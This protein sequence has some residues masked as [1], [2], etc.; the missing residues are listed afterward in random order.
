M[1]T[2]GVELNLSGESPHYLLEHADRRR[3]LIL[4]HRALIDSTLDLLG[5]DKI[6]LQPTNTDT[7][8]LGYGFDLS[9]DTSVVI[10]MPDAD[11]LEIEYTLLMYSRNDGDEDEVLTIARLD[12]FQA[13]AYDASD[14]LLDLETTTH[15]TDIVQQL[16]PKS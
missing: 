11:K 2:N 5:I 1:D 10:E 7:K 12:L 15:L 3:E 8:N 6:T 4:A 9:D 13:R 14:A 16:P